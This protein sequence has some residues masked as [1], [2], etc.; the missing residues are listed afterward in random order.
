MLV[1]SS[2]GPCVQECT[3]TCCLMGRARALSL[4]PLAWSTFLWR[5][6]SSQVRFEGRALF[7]HRLPPTEACWSEP[8]W[9]SP[10]TG[11]TPAPHMQRQSLVSRLEERR[12]LK[13]DAGGLQLR[14]RTCA[15]V[16]SCSAAG[17]KVFIVMRK[18][19]ELPVNDMFCPK[20]NAPSR[21]VYIALFHWPSWLRA[22]YHNQIRVSPLASSKWSSIMGFAENWTVSLLPNPS[23]QTTS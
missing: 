6:E 22:T 15:M 16:L 20:S 23:E 3:R 8:R 17:N 18:N 1:V 4:M 12:G 11:P 19:V 21:S 2:F 14:W 7:G 10:P 5:L 9:A 13:N